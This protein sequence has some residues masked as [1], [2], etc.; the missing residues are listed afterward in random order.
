MG[1]AG[2]ELLI[3]VILVVVSR[4][5]EQRKEKIKAESQVYNIIHCMHTKK[6]VDT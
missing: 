2:S 1:V 5:T 3:K 4:A 6:Y